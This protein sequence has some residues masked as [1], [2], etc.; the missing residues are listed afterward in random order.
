MSWE[1]GGYYTRSEKVNGRVV[2][3]YI[4]KGESAKLIAEM[5]H[6]ERERR[7]EA[8]ECERQAQKKSEELEA[9]VNELNEWADLLAKLALIV[10]GFHQ[11]HRGNWR[12]R[13]ERSNETTDP[14][15]ED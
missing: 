14:E 3:T 1:K 13:R 2:R 10:A 4:G 12:K 11:H 15:T 5:D 7:E 8:K 9:K 6:L